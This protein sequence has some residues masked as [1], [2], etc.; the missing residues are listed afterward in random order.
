MKINFTKNQFNT[1]LD[2]VQLG[3]CI[4]ASIDKTTNESKF[5]EMEQYLMSFAKDFNYEDVLYDPTENV[6]DLTVER[7]QE[8]HELIDEY[9]DM[10]FW[11]KL[12]YY[13]ARRDFKT[14]M[15][16]KPLAEEAAFQRLIEI[17]EKYHKYF[18]EN[19]VQFLK[20]EK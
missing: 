17:E 8:I 14:E 4:T 13:M 16:Q 12:V 20:I 11:D 9:E 3:Y 2:M 18:E 10:V 7:E 1:L 15:T 6:Y 19:G 5:I